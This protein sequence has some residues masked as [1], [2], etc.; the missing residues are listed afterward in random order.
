MTACHPHTQKKCKDANKR[1][2]VYTYS[3]KR[4]NIGKWL[5]KFQ[6]TW[7]VLLLEGLNVN[8]F[9]PGSPIVYPANTCFSHN[10][11]SLLSHLDLA[12]TVQQILCLHCGCL[13]HP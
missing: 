8:E 3:C 6:P 7:K 5:Q 10:N 12:D 9:N 11:I 4:S 2:S 1:G 13:Q